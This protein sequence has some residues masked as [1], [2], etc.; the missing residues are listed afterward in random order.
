MRPSIMYIV[1]SGEELS[2]LMIRPL[3]TIR[4]ISGM[5]RR[6]VIKLK[7]DA[8]TFVQSGHNCKYY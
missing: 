6:P 7:L 1:A 4:G 3:D 2:P 5:M 8:I